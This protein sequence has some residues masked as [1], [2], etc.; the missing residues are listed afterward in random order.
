MQ[1]KKDFISEFDRFKTR[2][3]TENPAFS[4]LHSLEKNLHPENKNERF[5]SLL[6]LRENL[7]RNDQPNAADTATKKEPMR[8][9]HTGSNSS[10]NLRNANSN[11]YN[12]TLSS[13]GISKSKNEIDIPD[14]YSTH[15]I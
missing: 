7:G 2:L 1:N 6:Q 5:S 4:A 14:P 15:T 9:S 3:S 12:E 10:L 11:P 8:I 13:L